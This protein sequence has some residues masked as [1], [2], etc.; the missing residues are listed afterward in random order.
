MTSRQGPDRP[1]LVVGL[2]GGIASGKSTVEALFTGHGV[3]VIDADAVARAVVEPGQPG[4]RQVVARF[5]DGILKPDGS[6]DRTALRQQVFD[7]PASRKR[8][9]AV[10]HPLVRTGLID[11][12]TT[13][14]SAYAVLSIPLLLESG[15]RDLVDRVLV[16]DLPSTEQITRLM[17]R[18][19]CEEAHA[20]AILDAQLDRETR[21]RAADDLI[22]NSGDRA[23]LAP[24]VE[25]L[26]HRYLTITTRNHKP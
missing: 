16:V 25:A 15:Q 11:H 24:Q 17:Q 23:A 20:R 5:G 19:G 10:I 7:D 2:T 1:A 3:A 4:L 9:E 26:H 12:L 21:R 18:D 8:L 6:L 14:R 13:V 22:D